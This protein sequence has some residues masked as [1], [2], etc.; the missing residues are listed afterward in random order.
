MTTEREYAQGFSVSVVGRDGAWSV[1]VVTPEGD[2]LP[3]VDG[4]DLEGALDIAA[5]H[6]REWVRDGMRSLGPIPEA[7]K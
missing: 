3:M 6:M 5:S 2:A 7:G 4:A 1:S